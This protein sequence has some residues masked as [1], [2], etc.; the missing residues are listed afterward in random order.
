[1]Q[2]TANFSAPEILRMNIEVGLALV[3]S[4]S[5]SRFRTRRGSAIGR[6]KGGIIKRRIQSIERLVVSA[7]GNT[8]RKA[9]EKRH[10]GRDTGYAGERSGRG[11]GA[12]MCAA[13]VKLV[14]PL[15]VTCRSNV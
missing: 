5:E 10:L 4:L 13:V 2:K 7:A 14:K 9:D 11:V 1:V 6:E 3:Q 8:N 15:K 12:W